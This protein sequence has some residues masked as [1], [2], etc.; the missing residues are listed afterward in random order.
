MAPALPAVEPWPAGRAPDLAALAELALPAERFTADELLAVCWDG[1]GS[2]AST[3]LGIPDGSG[4]VAVASRSVR[5]RDRPTAV[6]TC[7]AVEPAAQ[8]EGRGRALLAA[9]HEWARAEGAVSVAAAGLAPFYLWPGID[10]RFTR[11]L[12][13]AEAA[14]YRP[15]GAALNLSCPTTF[16]TAPPAGV[17][18]ERVLED[19]AADAVLALC[20]RAYPDW[21][22]EAARGIEHGAGHA[23]V[24]TATGGTV[25]FACHS[26]NRAG[27]VGPIGVEQ[28]RQGGGVGAALLSA[29]C[30]D[31]RAAGHADAEIAWIGPIGFYARTAGASVSRTFM[32]Y[33]FSLPAGGRG[34]RGSR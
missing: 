12:C 24:D 27:W 34:S 18:V 7:L 1:E 11:A 30:T 4:A 2:D 8:G 21:E 29:L 14:G 33:T 16:R 3:V 17:R 23:A 20:R 22:A 26:V 31:L 6:V 10:V 19:A 28:Q 32:T 5:G 13:L 9:A 15:T 25:G